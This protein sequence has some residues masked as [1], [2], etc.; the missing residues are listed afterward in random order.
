MG[1]LI[2]FNDAFA[3]IFELRQ[4]GVRNRNFCCET[5]TMFRFVIRMFDQNT[6]VVIKPTKYEIDT[7]VS[8]VAR[9]HAIAVYPRAYDEQHSFPYQ[10]SN[11]TRY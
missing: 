2:F 6:S 10:K 8:Q 4:L 7:F 9:N 3:L 1:T 11:L 5:T